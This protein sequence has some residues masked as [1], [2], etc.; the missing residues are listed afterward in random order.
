MSTQTAGQIASVS[1]DVGG[2]EI[3]FAVISDLVGA[4]FDDLIGFRRCDIWRPSLG[5]RQ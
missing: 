3:V 2:H 5:G 4:E 1:V